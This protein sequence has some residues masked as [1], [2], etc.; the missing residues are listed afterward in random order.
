MAEFIA[1]CVGY[2]LGISITVWVFGWIYTLLFIF[3]MYEELQNNTVREQDLEEFPLCFF[4]VNKEDKIKLSILYSF[5]KS[6][7]WVVYPFKFLVLLS[8]QVEL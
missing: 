3:T 4:R 6:F 8:K 2:Y 7:T 5:N 1:Q